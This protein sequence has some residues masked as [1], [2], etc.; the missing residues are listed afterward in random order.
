MIKLNYNYYKRFRIELQELLLA[1]L[2]SLTNSQELIK[3]LG[4]MNMSQRHFY[5]T[6]I[7]IFKA[8]NALTSATI[9][10]RFENTKNIHNYHTRFASSNTLHPPKPRTNYL[11]RSLSYKVLKIGREIKKSD[12]NISAFITS[13][14]SLPL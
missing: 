12:S 3:Q 5:F 7:L 4:W 2:I 1:I 13:L 6:V 14:R 11:K 10:N 9:C 8:R